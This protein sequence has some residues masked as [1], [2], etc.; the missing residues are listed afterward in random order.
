MCFNER[1][2][3]EKTWELQQTCSFL[4]V[5]ST[6]LV[7]K[8]WTLPFRIKFGLWGQGSGWFITWQK[9]RSIVYPYLCLH[10]FP[11][12]ILLQQMLIW[13]KTLKYAE[14]WWYDTWFCCFLHRWVWYHQLHGTQHWPA[15]TME[16]QLKSK[17]DFFFF[18]FF[19]KL[20]VCPITGWLLLTLL[21]VVVE[22]N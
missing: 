22:S 5:C 17:K 1:Q 16:V 6:Y 20:S 19:Q 9:I 3:E 11:P 2:T 15:V 14:T 12:V 4:G 10:I 18:L 8:N 7:H 21:F 13:Q